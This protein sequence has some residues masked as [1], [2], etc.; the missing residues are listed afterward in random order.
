MPSAGPQPPVKVLPV[1][2]AQDQQNPIF[3]DDVVHDPMIAHA[4]SM[5]RVSRALQG[6]GLLPPHA[7]REA[8]LGRE[9]LEGSLQPSALSV[10]QLAEG[11]RGTGGKLD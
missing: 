8:D 7:P 6:L 2:D 9:F 5:E 1:D 10:G 11:A 3:R 4:E